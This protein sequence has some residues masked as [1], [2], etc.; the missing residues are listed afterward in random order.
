[1]GWNEGIG[2]AVRGRRAGEHM[3]NSSLALGVCALG[4]GCDFATTWVGLEYQLAAEAKPGAA[5]LFEWLGPTTG[6]VLYEFWITT[7]VIFL[8]C[9]LTRKIWRARR[10]PRSP[11]E[12]PLLY[13]IGTISLAVAAYNLQFLV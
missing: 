6:L 9:Y 12:N 10:D 13:G 5:H 1:M 11:A 4:R 2:A 7:P 8:G 3:A